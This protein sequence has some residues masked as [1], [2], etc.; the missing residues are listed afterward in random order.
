MSAPL[1][2]QHSEWLSL[3]EISGPFLTLPV[4]KRAL[5]LGLDP[6]PLSLVSDLRVAWNEVSDDDSLMPRWIRW[7]LHDLLELPG[8]VVKDGTEIGPSLIFTVPEHGV[9]L[10]PD[11][12]I[13][14]PDR[15]DDGPPARMLV[16]TLP[17]G[18]KLDERLIGSKWS[19][20]AV[21]RMAELCRGSGVR[22]GLVTNGEHWAVVDAPVGGATGVAIWDASLWLEERLTLDAFTT[23]LGVR[24]FFSV[25]DTDT[26]EAMLSE[27]ANAEAEVTDQLGKQVRAAV[28]LLVDAMSRS[29]RDR[30]GH[31]FDDVSS[32]EVYEA[33]VT[34]M[35]RLVF[36]LSAE[37]RGLFLLGDE[38]YDTT[39]AVSTLRALLEE[40]ASSYGEEVIA[41]RGDAW[42]RLLATFRMVFGGARHEN[43]RL[44]AYG[45]SLF[46]PDRFPFLEG[47]RQG[48]S[49]QTAESNPLAIDNRT[50]LHILG[51]LQ[52]LT[53]TDR[54]GVREAR[55]L[56][57]R[58]L[59][60][61]QIGHVYEGLLDHSAVRTEQVAVGLTGKNEPE[62]ALDLIETKAHEG[63]VQLGAYLAELT[64]LTPKAVAKALSREFG[65]HDFET[66]A[67]A[68]DNDGSVAD[69]IAPYL[70]LLRLDLADLP[71]VYLPGSIYVTQ[72][73][74]RRS[75]GT[76]YTPRF[77]AEEMVQHTLEPLVYTPG[78]ADGID[79]D[80][81]NLKS[82]DQILKLKVCDMAMGSGAFLVATCRYLSARL[83]EAW[84]R[85][86]HPAG[87]TIRLVDGGSFLM[88]IEDNDREIL[89]R[90]LV[91][92]SCLYG[93]DRN[94]LAVEMAKLSM[95]LIT[96][97]KDRPFTFVDHAFRCGDSLL[98]ITDLRQ[99]DCLH[100]DPDAGRKIYGGSLF[101]PAK[102]IEPLVNAALDKRR[103]LEA[104]PV[105]DVRDAERKSGLLNESNALLDRLKVV[106]NIIVGAALSTATQ[107]SEAYDNQLRSVAPEVSAA[108]DET[109]SDADREQRLLDLRLKAEYWLDEGRP[110]MTAERRCFHWPIEF[111]EVF[112]DRTRTGFD[113]IIG[114]PP[115][116]GG[117]GLSRLFG[118]PY[119]RTLK[120][121]LPDSQGFV[122]YAVYFH[123]RAV[124]SLSSDSGLIT[125]L[126]PQNL[127]STV[128]RQANGDVTLAEG[129]QIMWARKRVTWPG[130]NLQ[131][132]IQSY[133]PG[134]W[135][136]RP[137][138]DGVQ[139]HEIGA[140]LESEGDLSS[141]KHLEPWVK[142]SQGTDLYGASFIKSE[143][144]WEPFLADEPTISN[145]LRPYV[146]ADI[147][148][149]NPDFRSDL[150]AIDFGERE[151]D[152]LHGVERLL[153]HLE[154]QVGDE[155]MHQTRQIHEDRNWLFWDKRSV[156][157][158]AARDFSHVIV[159]PGLSKHLPMT[160]V[161]SSF[162]FSKTVR[163]FLTDDLGTFAVLQSSLF[164]AWS[165]ATSRLRGSQVAFSARESLETFV[166]PKLPDSELTGIGTE[167]WDERL[168]AMKDRGV[169]I[170]GLLN[171]IHDPGA[172]DED[173]RRLRETIVK[174]DHKVANAYGWGDLVLDHGFHETGQGVRFTFSP[175]TRTEMLERMLELNRDRYEEQLT[176][177]ARH[178]KK[179]T[180]RKSARSKEAEVQLSL[181]NVLLSQIESP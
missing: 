126:G 77:M 171:L 82:S 71:K 131:V 116:V 102:C 122:D 177:G 106:G 22:L 151:K 10:R 119:E 43:L 57:F 13:V 168:I 24:R 114:N 70:G 136:P 178:N 112:L 172:S 125:L 121:T 95:W 87:D 66:L 7:V 155:R 48:Q 6:T 2:G 41:R 58:A 32:T 96:L 101:D 111:P 15:A 108:L 110:E 59:D 26:L 115:F 144:E 29:N 8:E 54:R 19:A 55:R 56:S 152:E 34:V 135:H 67:S 145:F 153:N 181:D 65:A 69:R 73:S 137:M 175:Q 88:P 118:V 36:L 63:P 174:V 14:D 132:C 180:R 149:S 53:F 84:D 154:L 52:V 78:P 18:T 93:V 50:V 105:M 23:L 47:R 97:A 60:V 35:M 21:D 39:Y 169:G 107:T 62:I 165:F 49:W 1:S 164:I 11:F 40:E 12:A 80:P 133:A 33:G 117:V 147:L 99:L 68:C 109:R 20:D 74:D 28:E 158:E 16:I 31:L 159:C 130:S 94:P 89:A 123:R 85:E 61:E 4:L 138:L 103:R 72:S 143:I 9:V 161:D 162:L 139:V 127:I 38:T 91:A 17:A 75:S 3:V 141:A 113:A 76:Y 166:P 64:G 160:L 92:D 167:C 157:Y 129:R 173:I 104:F 37:E 98:G 90:R 156:A 27:S 134:I 179:I 128:N 120:R 44:P 100:L 146:N 148:C 30:G 42:H 51:A 124:T 46:D 45:G 170:T 5:P 86:G 79:P 163:F 25:A 150:L 142:S 83:L 140:S 81:E 176:E